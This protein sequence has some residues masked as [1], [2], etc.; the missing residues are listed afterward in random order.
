MSISIFVKSKVPQ[1]IYTAIL[2][3]VILGISQQ[4]IGLGFLAWF[5]FIPWL[6][7]LV[8]LSDFKQ[9]IFSFFTF[10]FFYHLITIFWLAFNI[11]T[12]QWVAIVSMVSTVIF[13]SLMLLPGGLIWYILQKSNRS[14]LFAFPIVWTALE[15]FRSLGTLAFPWVSIANT[16]LSF[17][18]P[19]QIAE[20]TGI[21][22]VSFWIL[23]VNIAIYKSLKSKRINTW[24]ITAAIFC[25]PWIAG[26]VILETEEL[27]NTEFVSTAI[28]Q[29]NI[30]LSEKWEDSLKIHHVNTLIEL[31]T[32]PM[33][34][35]VDLIVWPETALPVYLLKSG[36]RYLRK[37][38]KVMENTS[39]NVLTGIPHYDY[40]DKEYLTYNSVVMFNHTDLFD[41]YKKIQLVPMAEYVPLSGIFP[42]LSDL[43]FGQANFI[44]GENH[45]LYPLK[46]WLFG[47]VICFESTLP[48]L[49]RQFVLEGANFITIVVNDGWYETAPEPQQHSRQAI[50][51][52]IENRRP[53]IRCANTGISMIIDPLGNIK[54]MSEL[55]AQIVINSSIYPQ[56]KKT[57]YTKFGDVFAEFLILIL[58]IRILIILR[59]NYKNEKNYSNTTILV[60]NHSSK[61]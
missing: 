17:F 29:P 31:S 43:N 16:Q 54:D 58:I 26:V 28:I 39:S 56:T 10:G 50:F 59:K 52:A 45:T 40:I 32:Q 1:Y 24:L 57:F 55:N 8:R 4:P 9:I 42:S 37:I 3:A 46:E 27:Q 23:L 11:G 36:R 2:S 44:R 61:S 49:I 51:R 15:Y 60:N 21:Y 6:T 12:N 13:L 34:H 38:R 20:Y 5:A 41:V 47:A 25:I 33:M 14:Q 18:Y 35:N 22:G 48:R 53:V 30:H 19:I 7:I